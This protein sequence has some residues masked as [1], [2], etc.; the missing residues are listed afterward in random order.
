MEFSICG[1]MSAF[2]KFRIL[3]HFGF[4]I[5]TMCILKLDIITLA[6]PGQKERERVKEKTQNPTELQG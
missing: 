3:E 4:Q 1:I 2:K 6:I 5:F